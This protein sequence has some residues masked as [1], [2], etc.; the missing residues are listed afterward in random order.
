MQRDRGVFGVRGSRYVFAR[1]ALS[2]ELSRGRIGRG[3][4]FDNGDSEVTRGRKTS[5]LGEFL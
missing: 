2:A 1:S 4:V 5:C 3:N